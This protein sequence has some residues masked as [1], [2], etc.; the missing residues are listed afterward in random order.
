MHPESFSSLGLT[1]ES[2][3][4]LSKMGYQTPTP[5]QAGAI[6]VALSG[7]DVIG[8][9]ATG[10]GKTAAFVLPL[11]ERLVGK[12]GFRALILAPTRELAAQIDE[13]ATRLGSSRGI[14]TAL[15]IGGVSPIPQVNAL[16]SQPQLLIATPGR[17]IDHLESRN[18]WLDG[19]E[20][21]VLDEADR[22]LDMG[23]KPQLTRI[24][25]RVPRERQTLLFS[26]TMGAE[27][28]AFSRTHLH[29]PVRV[30]VE[31]SGTAAQRATQ[32]VYLVPHSE[33]TALLLALLAEDE[34]STLI[35]ARTKHRAD[36]IARSIEQ[37]GH[38]VS[39]IHSN[40]SQSQR[41]QALHGFKSG[42][43]RVLVATDIAARG[44]DVAE[45]GHVV[46]FD[47]PHVPEDYVHRIGRTARAAASGKAS[48]FAAPEESGLLGAIERFMRN[49]VPRAQVP[50][51][52]PV[53]KSA[54]EKAVARASH[55]GPR[56]PGHG[57]S[58]RPPGRPPGRH[59]RSHPR[60]AHSAEG[61]VL[62][63][64]AAVATFREGTRRR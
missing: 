34:L 14:R 27:V 58:G 28:A 16:K 47:M 64:T 20:S 15:L 23:F 63:A 46:N 55:P 48:S 49:P 53:F 56:Q 31:R 24:L 11:L 6:P 35:F 41:Q 21:L 26:A 42:R 45:I 9:A 60:R 61:G 33:K 38:P 5:I 2:L 52:S 57:L 37:A 36:R 62:T 4:A 18:V 39:R 29:H 22:M 59:A 8:C 3:L 12:S 30:E 19:I 43:F 1:A 13:V 40:R 51:A 7:K 44:I 10:T 32:C 50:R 54:I 17:L 25:S